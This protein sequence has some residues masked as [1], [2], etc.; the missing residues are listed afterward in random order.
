[1][2][3][4]NDI[5]V[6]RMVALDNLESDLSDGLYSKLN[7]PQDPNRVV[8]GNGEIIGERDRR[9]VD[10]FPGMMIVVIQ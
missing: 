10:C 8:I 5:W 7:A 9:L 4:A 3:K 1:M 2:V 6:F